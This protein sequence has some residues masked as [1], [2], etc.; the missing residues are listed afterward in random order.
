MGIPCLT[1]CAIPFIKL[2]FS[3]MFSAICSPPC[4]QFYFPCFVL[5]SSC[6]ILS[7]AG[8]HEVPTAIWDPWLLSCL[9]YAVAE[10][11]LLRK[12]NA[13]GGSR[14]YGQLS[15]VLNPKCVHFAS[16]TLMTKY[17][18]CGWQMPLSKTITITWISTH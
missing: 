7:Q 5:G 17:W 10:W 6:A 8:L 4:G 15:L 12:A 18:G 3:F 14:V 1:L 16:V 13:K 9:G 11:L 2:F